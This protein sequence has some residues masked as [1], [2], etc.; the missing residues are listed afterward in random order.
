ML[1]TKWIKKSVSLNKL[2]FDSEDFQA[3]FYNFGDNKT[4]IETLQKKK[5]EEI[6][7]YERKRLE[8]IRLEKAEK[9][10]KI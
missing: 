4:K 2:K 5:A 7:D 3:F 8:K 6:K 10:L 1:L 9:K